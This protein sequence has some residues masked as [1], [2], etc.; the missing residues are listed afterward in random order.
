[1]LAASEELEVTCWGSKRR[2]PF[3][4]VDWADYGIFDV[5]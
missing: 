1:M 2:G 3:L 5:C 4:E